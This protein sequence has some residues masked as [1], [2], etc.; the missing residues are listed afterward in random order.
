MV[1]IYIYILFIQA[2]NTFK[3][4]SIECQEPDKPLDDRA[5]IVL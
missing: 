3:A 4:S 5:I 1:F 2:N